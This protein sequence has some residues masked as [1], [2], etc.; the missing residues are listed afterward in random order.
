MQNKNNFEQKQ[1]LS[2]QKAR[3]YVENANAVSRKLFRFDNNKTKISTTFLQPRCDPTDKGTLEKPFWYE[4]NKIL[5]K[6]RAFGI[7]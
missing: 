7:Q 3:R 2:W 4:D 1:Q 6:L 5:P